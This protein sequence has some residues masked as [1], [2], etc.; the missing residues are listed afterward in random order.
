M[1]FA[2]II[3]LCILIVFAVNLILFTIAVKN[4][5]NFNET[6]LRPFVFG[7]PHELIRI[8]EVEGKFHYTF[9][10]KI[11]NV[12]KTPAFNLITLFEPKFK[13]EFPKQE[14][15]NIL[16]RGEVEVERGFVYPDP[17]GIV[18]KYLFDKYPNG[19]TVHNSRDEIIEE[20]E[21]KKLLNR[22]I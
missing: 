10:F 4:Q 13:E 11:K 15:A 9:S 6:S 14:F 17:N 19:D 8:E 12:G 20:L 21:K 7:I 16:K 1:D 22:G 2:E 18:K 5:V 3:Q